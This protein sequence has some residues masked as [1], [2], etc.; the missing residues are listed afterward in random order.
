MKNDYTDITILLD[1]SGSMRT[2]KKAT[3]EGLK[4][5]IDSQRALPGEV[6]FS[7]VTF[8]TQGIEKPFTES[9]EPPEF[10]LEP[11]GG[12]PLFDAIVNTV[13]ETGERLNARDESEKPSKVVFVIV[14]DGEENSSIK[15]KMASQVAEVITHQQNFYSWQFIF[16]GAN[17]DAILSAQQIGILSQAALSY[18]ANPNS[19]KN[20]YAVASNLVG[21]V[22]ASCLSNPLADS[23]GKIGFSAEDRRKAKTASKDTH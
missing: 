17:Q 18:N 16:L 22:R 19:T 21:A 1:R 10:T 3:E 13:K 9:K 11:R 7:L 20:S 2:I 4:G 5:F 6:R 12:T 8:D 14:T 23:S 15:N